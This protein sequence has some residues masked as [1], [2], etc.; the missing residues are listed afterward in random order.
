MP[1]LTSILVL[2]LLRLREGHTSDLGLTQGEDGL[3]TYWAGH[4]QV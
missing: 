4:M 2:L 3:V 1:S